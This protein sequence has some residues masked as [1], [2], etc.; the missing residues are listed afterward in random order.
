MWGVLSW[1][2]ETELPMNESQQKTSFYEMVKGVY[3]LGKSKGVK[4]DD[5]RPSLASTYP[6]KAASRGRKTWSSTA[7]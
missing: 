6:S 3:M 5:E 4:K 2:Y 1:F 7:R